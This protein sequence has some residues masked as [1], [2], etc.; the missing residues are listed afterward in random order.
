MSTEQDTRYPIYSV[1]VRF[2][3]D[4]DMPAE[5]RA[6]MRWWPNDPGPGAYGIAFRP[7]GCTARTQAPQR[8]SGGA[9]EEW[10]PN[11][12][13]ADRSTGRIADKNP[14]DPIFTVALKYHESWCISWF[15][16]WTFDVGQ[17]DE[18]A[19]A[20]FQR[21]VDRHAF[22]QDWHH[23]ERTDRELAARGIPYRV[24][25]MGAEDRWRWCAGRGR[26]IARRRPA[27]ANTVSA[28]QTSD[29]T[30]SHE[31]QRRHKGRGGGGRGAGRS[32][33]GNGE[34]GRV[35]V[36]GPYCA[37][38]VGLQRPTL[39]T[40]Q[41]ILEGQGLQGRGC[42][43]D[44]RAGPVA[45]YESGRVLAAVFRSTEVDGRVMSKHEEQKQEGSRRDRGAG[46]ATPSLPTTAPPR[47]A[48]G[49]FRTRG[50]DGRLRDL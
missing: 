30:L 42:L 17:S 12:R 21:Y 38:E 18:E 11:C 41:A 9:R 13:D 40:E 26:M 43:P 29:R 49:S 45:R 37:R 16:H 31:H 34:G 20:S 6:Q 22:Y 15:E 4:G 46:W 50:E 39:R 2:T 48:D 33:R 7:I 24:C 27:G 25:L 28:G 32:C 1:G 36:G 8:W 3:E 44:A 47:R 10:W 35:A 14:G 19:L 5:E 23:D